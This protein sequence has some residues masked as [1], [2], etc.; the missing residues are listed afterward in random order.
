MPIDPEKQD[1]PGLYR[2][3]LDKSPVV[4]KTYRL[5][6]E[7]AQNQAAYPKPDGKMVSCHFTCAA[8]WLGN[9]NFEKIATGWRSYGGKDDNVPVDDRHALYEMLLQRF[10][11]CTYMIYVLGVVNGGTKAREGMAVERLHGY[12]TY[13]FMN[14]V[15]NKQF[16]VIL[17]TPIWVNQF[18]SW[19]GPSLMQS[20]LWF[21]PRVVEPGCFVQHTGGIHGLDKATKFL[22]H[23]PL[24]CEIPNFD[25]LLSKSLATDPRYAQAKQVWN[26]AMKHLT[27]VAKAV[28]A[29]KKWL[30]KAV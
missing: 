27:P 25:A 29:T 15:I 21:P 28:D 14:Y 5:T 8:A 3:P 4:G 11:D 24:K 22:Q 17:E 10:K 18:H 20:W 23:A 9:I 13:D 2:T 7:W 1:M 6:F 19:K 12:Y 16:G 26:E 30:K